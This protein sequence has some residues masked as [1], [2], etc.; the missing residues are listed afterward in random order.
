MTYGLQELAQPV[1]SP[2]DI[3]DK[4]ENL[5]EYEDPHDKQ[6]DAEAFRLQQEGKECHG[7][8]HQEYPDDQS[9]TKFFKGHAF[10]FYGIMK[11][12]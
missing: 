9:G 1:V 3:A 4:Q 2:V 5:D 11:H 8:D 12:V 10:L 6:A 7:Y